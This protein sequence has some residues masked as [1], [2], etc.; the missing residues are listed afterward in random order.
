ML[1]VRYVYNEPFKFWSYVA[2]K[3]YTKL[4]IKKM[5]LYIF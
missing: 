4:Y 3:T 1:A 5:R 2:I